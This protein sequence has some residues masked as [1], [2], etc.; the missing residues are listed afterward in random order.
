MGGIKQELG[1]L[2]LEATWAF[3]ASSVVFGE[4]ATDRVLNDGQPS[5]PN[6]TLRMAPR[7]CGLAALDKPFAD[8]PG[9][10]CKACLPP[11]SAPAQASSLPCETPS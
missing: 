3:I 10:A 11:E 1:R 6:Q 7:C 5:A 9:F 4:P 8:R 2:P